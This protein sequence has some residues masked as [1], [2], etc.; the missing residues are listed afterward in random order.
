MQN[1]FDIFVQ[2]IKLV[3]IV[4]GAFWAYGKFMGRVTEMESRI[5]SL[6]KEFKRR[7]EEFSKL[8]SRLDNDYSKLNAKLDQVSDKIIDKF[9][10][11]FIELNKKMD[12]RQ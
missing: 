4:C 12:R 6:E 11:I 3:G 7:D 1:Q 10:Q 8:E 2:V 9:S 5:E